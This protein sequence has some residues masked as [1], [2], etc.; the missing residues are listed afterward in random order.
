MAADIVVYTLGWVGDRSVK[1]GEKPEAQIRSRVVIDGHEI[2]S[3]YHLTV[4]T[5]AVEFAEA[6]ARITIGTI[7]YEPLDSEA[8]YSPKSLSTGPKV[9]T[10]EVSLESAAPEFVRAALALIEAVDAQVMGRGN[11][12]PLIEAAARLKKAFGNGYDAKGSD[13]A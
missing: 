4:E 13:A 1:P 5:D 12:A 2:P 10:V 9:A 3:I 6:T 7:R 11:Y 8:F